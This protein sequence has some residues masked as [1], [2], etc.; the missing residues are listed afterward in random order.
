V[1]RVSRERTKK[2]YFT[3]CIA[4]VLTSTVGMFNREQGDDA[5]R[6]IALVGI[7]ALLMVIGMYFRMGRNG[8]GE[9]PSAEDPSAD[10][11]D[12]RFGRMQ[13]MTYLWY[14]LTLVLAG[15]LVR[16]PLGVILSGSLGEVGRVEMLSAVFGF[17]VIGFAIWKIL[18]LGKKEPT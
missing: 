18:V 6:S 13:R 7:I 17:V 5:P 12:H 2:E 3:A 14:V 10:D 15:A 1:T 11:L 8:A 9:D 4:A 16:G